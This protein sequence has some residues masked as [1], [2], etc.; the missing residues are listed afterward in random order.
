MSSLADTI[1]KRANEELARD[2]QVEA[3]Q[4][5][6]HAFCLQESRQ[7]QLAR[8]LEYRELPPTEQPTDTITLPDNLRLTVNDFGSIVVAGPCPKCGKEIYTDYLPDL[9]T[10]AWRMRNWPGDRCDCASVPTPPKPDPLAEITE[11]IDTTLSLYLKS[12]EGH[13]RD[14]ARFLMMGHTVRALVE[15]ARRLPQ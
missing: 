4:A 2:A 13:E 3:E 10:L 15:I 1:I 14:F 8:W 5:L 6:R 11:H 7:K 9:A 12:D